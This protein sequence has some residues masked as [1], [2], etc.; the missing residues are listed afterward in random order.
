M[1]YDTLPD[2]ALKE[3]LMLKEAEARLILREKAQNNFMPF[4]H[5]VYENF[6][7]GRHH[8]EIAEKLEKVALKVGTCILFNACVVLGP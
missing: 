8:L 4:V 2:E 6:I 5:H 3:F 1:R 7:E